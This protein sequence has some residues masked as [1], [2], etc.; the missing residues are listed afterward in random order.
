M[1]SVPARSVRECE[2]VDPRE[3]H[4]PRIRFF[5]TSREKNFLRLVASASHCGAR[6][7]PASRSRKRPAAPHARPISTSTAQPRLP[8]KRSWSCWTNCGRASGPERL[9]SREAASSRRQ[10]T[11][12]GTDGAASASASRPSYLLAHGDPAS[13]K[14]G[15]GGRV[16]ART[17][18]NNAE[19]TLSRDVRAA[20]AAEINV[21]SDSSPM[22]D[23]RTWDQPPG[24][25]NGDSLV[26]QRRL[27]G[28]GPCDSGAI[29]SVSDG[30]G[31][32]SL[33]S[34]EIEPS[35]MLA[36]VPS[37]SSSGGGLGIQ[38]PGSHTWGGFFMPTAPS[39][40]ADESATCPAAARSF[41][42]RAA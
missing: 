24:L 28:R 7:S 26:L 22:R 42:G 18:G 33:P 25:T 3:A 29:N 36:S 15:E 34:G 19:L 2:L 32:R 4:R 8:M 31:L 6:T 37:E 40:R 21:R 41:E 11:G 23:G 12:V 16:L 39:G 9:P 27:T 20:A 14:G 30:A 35:V 38:Q 17:T 1:T 10:I 13:V 5:E